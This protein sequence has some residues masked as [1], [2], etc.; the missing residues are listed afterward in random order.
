MKGLVISFFCFS[1]IAFSTNVTATKKDGLQIRDTMYVEEHED[2]DLL[3]FI[4]QSGSYQ[5]VIHGLI[6]TAMSFKVK[7]PKGNG[8][9][10]HNGTLFGVYYGDCEMI[11]I[12]TPLFEK[13]RDT[14][15]AYDL[16]WNEASEIV[17]K[18]FMLFFE[19][20]HQPC[21]ETMDGRNQ[22][23]I[24]IAGVKIL[25]FNIKGENHSRYAELLQSFQEIK[26]SNDP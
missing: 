12:S 19:F 21:F 10:L 26:T 24:T 1:Q 4:N 6:D 16:N 5:Y 18:N 25:L 9:L 20:E 8:D 11:F 14:N 17:E 23:F 13:D 3:V 2:Y 7:I 15:I 22:T